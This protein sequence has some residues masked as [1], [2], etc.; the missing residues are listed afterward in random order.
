[1]GL[2]AKILV[3]TGL[4]ILGVLGVSTLV[5]IRSSKRDYLE[6]LEWRSESLAQSISVDIAKWSGTQTRNVKTALKGSAFQCR[7]LYELN[8]K[9]Q[10]T[11]VAV[12]DDAGILSRITIGNCKIPGDKCGI[13][14]P[15]PSS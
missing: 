9:K 7:Q 8:Q 14:R 1:M 6:A 10:V 13:A 4:I 3:S 5:H 2:R 15:T 12:I 11:H